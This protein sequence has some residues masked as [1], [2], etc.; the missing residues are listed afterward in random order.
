MKV[1]DLKESLKSMGFSI[2]GKKSD[3]KLWLQQAVAAGVQI[4]SEEET[5]QPHNQMEVLHPAAH[6][7]D[8]EQMDEHVDYPRDDEEFMEPTVPEGE[9]E[10]RK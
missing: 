2:A 7:E 1:I 5:Q 8:L 3:L 9:S 10:Q 4:I 6:W